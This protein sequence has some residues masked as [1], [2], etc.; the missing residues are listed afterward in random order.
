MHKSQANICLTLFIINLS[1]LVTAN[2]STE[3]AEIYSKTCSV[4][5]GEQ[6]DGKSHAMAG[7][8]P[9][10]KDFSKPGLK[11]KL[12][13]DTMIQIVSHGKPGTAMSG[14]SSQLTDV[15][16]NEL[17][18]YVRAQFMYGNVGKSILKD[19]NTGGKSIYALTCSV[20][21]GEDGSGAVWGK[22]SLNPP[23]VNFSAKDKQRDLPRERMINSV[24]YGRPG[25]AMTA[26]ATQLSRKQAEAVVDYIRDSFMIESTATETTTAETTA[27]TT[28]AAVSSTNKQGHAASTVGMA[29]LH[30]QAKESDTLQQV[31]D[32]QLFTQPLA[33]QLQGNKQTGLAY[34]IQNCIACHGTS[35]KGDGPRAYFIYPRPRNFLHPASKTRFN[36]PVLFKAIKEG[37]IGREMPA[38]GKVLNDQ[39]I[40]DLTEYVF[41]TFIQPATQETP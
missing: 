12:T 11:E 37:V 25:T 1:V 14:F 8:N 18:D 31:T 9:P 40:A 15:Q 28:T 24:L 21:H 23:P 6:G 26:F 13:R 20:C 33:D 2:A 7:L 34:Y 35:G 27:T 29:V 32:A 22:T 4:C 36:R 5:H 38:W 3:S 39:Q 41:Q 10:P 16:I 17:V 19:N 30:D